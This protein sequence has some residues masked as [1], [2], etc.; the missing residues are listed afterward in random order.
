MVCTE[1]ICSRHNMQQINLPLG[2]STGWICWRRSVYA[3]T[4]DADLSEF[5]AW[6]NSYG[7]ALSN[8]G[9]VGDTVGRP[10][11]VCFIFVDFL[12]AF[13]FCGML[14]G[15]VVSSLDLWLFGLFVSALGLLE[16]VADLGTDGLTWDLLGISSAKQK[17]IPDLQRFD[18][19]CRFYL[20][21]SPLINF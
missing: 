20:A 2:R 19:R 3:C 5:H 8:L 4:P 15:L 21:L 1:Q 10:V 13:F 12:L 6:I 11:L 9:T 16:V 7:E 17:D 18:D 14:C